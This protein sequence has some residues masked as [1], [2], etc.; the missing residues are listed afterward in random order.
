MTFVK[1]NKTDKL[2]V[3]LTIGKSLYLW[4]GEEGK[5]KVCRNLQAD[6]KY[7]CENAKKLE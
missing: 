6:S 1:T 7:I 2:L 4:G 5:E 3:K